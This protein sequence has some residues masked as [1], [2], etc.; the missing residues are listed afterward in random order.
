M[1][2]GPDA[3]RFAHSSDLDRFRYRPLTNCNIPGSSAPQRNLRECKGLQAN[4]L[5]SYDSIA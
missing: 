3:K 5:G 4:V 2:H 1:E